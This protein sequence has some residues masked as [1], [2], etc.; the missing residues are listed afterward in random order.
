[1]LV[2]MARTLPRFC[3]PIVVVAVALSPVA[4]R[5][6]PRYWVTRT[7]IGRA[8]QTQTD[9]SAAPDS[10]VLLGQVNS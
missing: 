8:N 3:D 10:R 5:S 1:M 2:C 4:P 7:K 6:S 9:I